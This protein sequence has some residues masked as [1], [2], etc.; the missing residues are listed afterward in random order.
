MKTGILQSFL[1][2]LI[3]SFSAYP[4]DI[5]VEY[6]QKPPYIYTEQAQ[7][8]GFLNERT[9]T[10]LNAAQ[11]SFHYADVPAKRI[12][13]DLKLNQK[14]ICSPSWYK[15]PER[16][17]FAQFSLPIHQ[18][19]PHTVLVAER[20]FEHAK[21]HTTLASLLSDSR[22]KLGAVANVSY[23]EH[24][25]SVIQGLNYSVTREAKSV[26]SL[27]LMVAM[28]HGADFMFIDQH[29]YSYLNREGELTNRDLKL[30][31]LVDMPDGMKR[32]LM[33]SKKVAPQTMEKINQ[34]IL[35]LES[36]WQNQ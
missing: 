12:F 1:L 30:L 15:I 27:T 7:P 36:S 35:A 24:L 9:A 11:L 34:A 13:H 28:G 8:A 16:E 17:V 21:V 33:C 20:V 29:D 3:A 6:Y 26:E 32:Y 18:D 14:Q 25:D 4:S 19:K 31:S 2:S 5:V 10:I 22:L 23:G